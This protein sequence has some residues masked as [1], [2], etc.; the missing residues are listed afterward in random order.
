MVNID[1]RQYLITAR[2]VVQ[3]KAHGKVIQEIKDGDRIEIFF[4]GAW[5][6]KVGRPIFAKNEADAVALA[7]DSITMPGL[8]IPLGTAGIALGQK[9]FFSGFHSV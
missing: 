6:P 9:V 1:G 5:V 8:D 3:E 7:P 2:H 4:E